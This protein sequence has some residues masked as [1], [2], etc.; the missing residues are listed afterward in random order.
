M[1]HQ[2]Q[3]TIENEKIERKHKHLWRTSPKIILNPDKSPC[4]PNHWL[5][6]ISFLLQNYSCFTGLISIPIITMDLWPSYVIIYINDNIKY[7]LLCLVYTNTCLI[8]GRVCG[9]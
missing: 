4:C 5:L 6:A 3:A 9:C 8:A 7:F 2:L 1:I